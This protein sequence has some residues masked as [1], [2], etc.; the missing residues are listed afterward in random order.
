[1][2]EDG[3]WRNRI[4]GYGEIAVE[5]IL[6]NENNWRIHSI[7]QQEEMQA[8]LETIGIIQNVI[9]NKRTSEEWASDERGIETMVDG[10]MRV[11]L[12]MRRGQ[13]K[14][15]VTYVDLTPSEEAIALAT[16]DPLG[17][18]AGTNT[19]ALNALLERVA[20]DNVG[21]QKLL[22]EL[23]EKEGLYAQVPLPP[24]PDLDMEQATKVGGFTL[25]LVVATDTIFQELGELLKDIIAERGW[26]KE[27]RIEA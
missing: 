20:T 17:T 7:A 2:A 8:V 25:R 13:K 4:V 10:H 12:A 19:E 6:A 11:A 9:I 26:E 22:G 14:L 3:V 16:F 18:L 1:M 27:V 24:L 21:V 15:P 23:A 5:D